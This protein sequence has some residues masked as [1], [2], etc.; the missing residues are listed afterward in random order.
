MASIPIEGPKQ[1]ITVFR[2]DEIV[3]PR[4]VGRHPWRRGCGRRVVLR[5]RAVPT[6]P[7]RSVSAPLGTQ[8]TQDTAVVG[9]DP[10]FGEVTVVV[11][12]EDIDQLE[13]D[14]VPGRGE[15]SDGAVRELTDEPAGDRGLARDVV[16]LDDDDAAGDGEVV[17]GG[18]QRREVGSRYSDTVLAVAMMPPISGKR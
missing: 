16:P 15:R 13:H 9:L 4:S 12:A 3:V 10:L 1:T 6:A 14:Q 11:A 2:K 17:E 7:Q 8:L 18:S 5:R